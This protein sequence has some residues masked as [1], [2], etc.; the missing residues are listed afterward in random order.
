MVKKLSK[1]EASRI[2]KLRWAKISKKKR[3][4]HALKMNKARWGTLKIKK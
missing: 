2:A 4:E 1:K 3:T